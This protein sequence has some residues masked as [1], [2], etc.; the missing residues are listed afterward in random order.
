MTGDETV[1]KE[2][3]LAKKTHYILKLKASRWR[4][5]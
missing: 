5:T 1:Y 2:K 3:E 4:E